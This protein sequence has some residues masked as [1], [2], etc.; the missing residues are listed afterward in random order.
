VDRDCAGTGAHP[1][2]MAQ[3]SF[4][5]LFGWGIFSLEKCNRQSTGTQ[6]FNQYF[7]AT[8]TITS[9]VSYFRIRVRVRVRIG[10]SVRGIVKVT[11]RVEVGVRVREYS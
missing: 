6:G 8:T 4:V 5:E 11:V 9:I 7:N 10:V 2:E 3:G 1:S